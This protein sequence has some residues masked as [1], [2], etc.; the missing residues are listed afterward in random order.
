MG[1][2]TILQIPNFSGLS[3]K[4]GVRYTT[5]KSG[6]MKDIGNPMRDMTAEERTYLD[7]FAKET[8]DVFIAHVTKFRPN[9]KNTEEM[10]D[11]RPVGAKDALGNGLIDGFGRYYDAYDALLSRIGEN[12]GKNVS[13]EKFEKKRGL[14]KKLFGTFSTFSMES[15]LRQYTEPPIFPR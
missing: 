4:I 13:V 15:V 2:E 1:F 14:L 7:G 10:F 3:D 5:I 11:G 9:I 12:T 6:K 8:H